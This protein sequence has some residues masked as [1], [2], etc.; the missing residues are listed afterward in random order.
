MA[1]TA[2]S[3][4]Q[5]YGQAL[6]FTRLTNTSYSPIT[7][8]QTQTSSNYTK[9]GAVLNYSDAEFSGEIQQGDRKVIA[10]TYAY[11]IGDTVSIDGA[12]YRII[13]TRSYNPAGTEVAVVL[14]VRK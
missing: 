13:S 9:Q 8:Q 7:G 2:L 3:L 1:D 14:Q 4:L 11:E 12:E 5:E 6:T 10:E